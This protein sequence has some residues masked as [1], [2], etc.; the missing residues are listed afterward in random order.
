MNT[1]QFH[2][3]KLVLA[4]VPLSRCPVAGGRADRLNLGS[5]GDLNAG[6]EPIVVRV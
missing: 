4:V 2:A 5:V 1:L 6:I 3:L